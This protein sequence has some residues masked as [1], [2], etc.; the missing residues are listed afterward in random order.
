MMRAAQ[1][2]R[3]RAAAPRVDVMQRERRLAKL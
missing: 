2:C 1:M 3:H